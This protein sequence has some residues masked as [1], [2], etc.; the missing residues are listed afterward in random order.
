M[1]QDPRGERKREDTVSGLSTDVQ[2]DEIWSCMYRAE[3][4]GQEQGEAGT[5]SLHLEL[6]TKKGVRVLKTRTEI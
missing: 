4:K 2:M 6:W 5:I 1:G 3:D